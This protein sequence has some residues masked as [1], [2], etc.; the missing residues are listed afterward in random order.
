MLYR[1]VAELV[2][3]TTDKYCCSTDVKFPLP[4]FYVKASSR[5]EAMQIAKVVTNA[6]EDSLEYEGLTTVF[7]KVEESNEQPVGPATA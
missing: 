1:V 7:L 2:H 3:H 5:E 6:A 4:A